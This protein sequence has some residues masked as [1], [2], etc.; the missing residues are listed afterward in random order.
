MTDPTP[1]P[2][3]TAAR[4]LV[5]STLLYPLLRQARESSLDSDLFHGGRGEEAFAQRL[6]TLL[7]D[8]ITGASRLPIVDAIAE[9]LD[10]SSAALGSSPR[11]TPDATNANGITKREIDIYG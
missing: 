2:A 11:P 5:A 9:R 1:S 4:D 3:R 8:R 10:A 6:D 7:A